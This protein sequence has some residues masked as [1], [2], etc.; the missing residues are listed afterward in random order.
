M[1]WQFYG[2]FYIFFKNSP[3][4]RGLGPQ[5]TKLSFH[6]FG[7]SGVTFAFAFFVIFSFFLGGEEDLLQE[8]CQPEKLF[9]A[10]K[11]AEKKREAQKMTNKMK[12]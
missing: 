12:L 2:S 7:R 6:I 4:T 3:K 8:F 11:R 1:S 10:D 9:A 5:L